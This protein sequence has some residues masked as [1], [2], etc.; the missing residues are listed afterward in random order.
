MRAL[1]A[2]SLI[3]LASPLH[4]VEIPLPSNVALP[5]LGTDYY[6]V[7]NP[8]VCYQGGLYENGTNPVPNDHAYA[9][10]Q[11]AARV[12]PINGKIVLLALGMS[13]AALEFGRF[14][15][16]YINGNPAVNPHLKVINAA[17]G[18]GPG[19]CDF[20]LANGPPNS[21]CNDAFTENAYDYVRD[22]YLTPGGVTERQ[23]EVIWYKF[24][25][26]FSAQLAPPPT[27]PDARANAFV[28]E[29]YMG[30]ALR[31][32]K[33]RYPNIKLV[34]ITSRIYGGYDQ[35]SKSPEP[36]AYES[37]FATKFLI[38]AQIDQA[39]RGG[40]PDPVAG[41]L[42]Y[43]VAP[44]VAWGPY[45][46]ANGETPDSYNG[47]DWC[48]G[49]LSPGAPCNGAEQDFQSDLLHPSCAGQ[50]KVAA[51]LWDFFSTSE[52]TA[53]WFLAP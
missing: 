41:D 48:A 2:L 13:N 30:G 39:D 23:V 47:V 26:P 18:G 34:F 20:T 43:D 27:L 11:R 19:P 44:W 4:A 52:L 42:G 21:V 25:V 37:G 6:C 36:Y 14:Q 1:I 22:T 31:A 51:Q 17:S 8:P 49:L 35:A 29:G 3:L 5:D 33:R 10:S 53:G 7:G 32:I 50:T 46:W 45:I 16:T 28:Y 12:V 15:A 40:G 9:G 24:A 38:Q